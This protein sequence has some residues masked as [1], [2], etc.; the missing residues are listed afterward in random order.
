MST[1]QVKQEA[2]ATEQVATQAA[3]A[4]NAAPEA[5][6]TEQAK[7]DATANAQPKAQTGESIFDGLD[8]PEGEAPA[9]TAPNW[10]ENWRDLA[11][12]GDEKLAKVI[13]RYQSPAG[14]AKALANAQDMIRSGELKRGLPK[15]ASPEDVAKW[16]KENGLPEKPD[17][18]EIPKVPGI[19]IEANHPAMQSFKEA[20]FK[21]NMSPEQFQMAA[22][23]Y[24]ETLRSVQEE[25]AAQDKAA[26][27]E[28][29]EALRAEWGTEYR[30]NMMLAD[31]FLN[32]ELG[33]MKAQFLAARLP[34]GRSLGN[35]PAVIKFLAKMALEA[36]GGVGLIRGD[37]NTAK[38]IDGRLSELTAMMN[39]PDPAK[40][41]A[42]WSEKIQSEE[43][44]LIARKEKLSARAA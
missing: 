39:S 10:P 32:S 29:E 28:T 26:R 35:D 3:P 31:R 4:A 37:A 44:E 6:A 33:E 18:Y 30:P 25:R 20:A 36:D 27:I 17:A 22:G 21:A 16:R 34:D 42:Y 38:D 7:P 1:E 11:A 13:A 23:W 19:E 8:Q 43:R 40:R 9:R 2:T 5:K 41:A 15:D 24:A 12:G 14:L